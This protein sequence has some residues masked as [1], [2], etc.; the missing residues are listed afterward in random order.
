MWITAATLSKQ[1]TGCVGLHYRLGR[2]PSSA[3]VWGLVGVD[4]F[5]DDNGSFFVLVN[6]EEQHSLCPT[7]A[8]VPA[9]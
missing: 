3:R 6:D 7:F 8:D 9:G 1:R 2:V 5:D 4:P